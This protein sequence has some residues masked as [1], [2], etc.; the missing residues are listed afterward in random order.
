MTAMQ[1]LGLTSDRG[2]DARVGRR[3]R[4]DRRASLRSACRTQE[5]PRAGAR[6]PIAKFDAVSIFATAGTLSSPASRRRRRTNYVSI[7]T[8]ATRML[9]SG[10][11]RLVL[12]S[13]PAQGAAPTPHSDS[14][15]QQRETL[16]N[17]RER[18]PGAPPLIVYDL[19]AAPSHRRLTMK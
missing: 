5:G 16:P 2:P 10:A 13:S 8:A 15:D 1:Q 3:R 9:S 19:L 14:V 17:R 12:R 18:P 6:A 7:V 4:R 11:D